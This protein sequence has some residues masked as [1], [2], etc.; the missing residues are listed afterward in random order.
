MLFCQWLI[1]S[2]SAQAA[3]SLK[4]PWICEPRITYWRLQLLFSFNSESLITN[5]ELCA[6]TT[7]LPAVTQ[8]ARF[9]SLQWQHCHNLWITAATT[10]LAIV[11]VHAMQLPSCFP[12]LTVSWWKLVDYYTLVLS[13]MQHAKTCR[14]ERPPSRGSIRQRITPCAKEREGHAFIFNG[15]HF[16]IWLFGTEILF[17]QPTLSEMLDAGA[18]QW[19]RSLLCH[20]V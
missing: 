14:F 7:T 12:V 18:K 11:H 3:S 4:V 8:T 10:N 16:H 15:T 9:T 6:A 2:D 5:Y 13:H 20:D 17:V 1:G 19:C